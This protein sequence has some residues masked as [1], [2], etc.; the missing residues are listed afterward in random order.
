MDRQDIIEIG[1]RFIRKSKSNFIKKEIALSAEVE[2]MRIFDDP[3]FALGDADDQYFARLK[4]P[5]IVGEHFMLPKEWLSQAKTVI[6][7]FLPFSKMVKN[8]NKKDKL[9]P[10]EGW[11]H[12]RIEGQTLLNSLSLQLHKELLKQGYQSIIPSLSKSYWSRSGYNTDN[13]IIDD[14]TRNLPVFTS[15]WSERHVG[16]V[17]GLGTFG[18]SRG[19]ITKKGVAGRFG[20]MI[21]DLHMEPDMREYDHFSEYC[22]G[23]GECIKQCPVHAISFKEGK[24]HF[25]CSEFLEKIRIKYQPRFGCGKCQVNVPCENC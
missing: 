14:Q 3:I 18:L 21:T 24:S 12:G 19:L 11:L 6:S 1:L 25:L 16:F 2:G 22:S 5:S 9:W 15:N 8:S 23:C 10:S 4:D 20:S 13:Q 17:C 7:F